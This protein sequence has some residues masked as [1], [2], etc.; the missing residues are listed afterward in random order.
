MRGIFILELIDISKKCL[1]RGQGG[2]SIA[3][4]GMY[5]T[6]FALHGVSQSE[7]LRT[8]KLGE[9][10]MAIAIAI[11]AAWWRGGQ[12]SLHGNGVLWAKSAGK[13]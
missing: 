12:W 3:C 4:F 5:Q 13:F 7:E 8:C 6:D 9:L 11:R 10:E 1:D 2:S